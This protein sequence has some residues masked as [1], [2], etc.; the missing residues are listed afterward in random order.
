MEDT[1][2]RSLP[3]D[4]KEEVIDIFPSGLEKKRSK[5]SPRVKLGIK[6]T[7]LYLPWKFDLLPATPFG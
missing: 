7:E 6:A 3:M 1:L 2:P 5:R 4:I